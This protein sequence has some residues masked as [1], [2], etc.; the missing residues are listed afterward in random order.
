MIGEVTNMSESN[1]WKTILISHLPQHGFDANEICKLLD[2]ITTAI[3]TSGLNDDQKNECIRSILDVFTAQ[4]INLKKLA[5]YYD[6]KKH[7]FIDDLFHA[8]MFKIALGNKLRYHP[9][10]MPIELVAHI[11]DLLSPKLNDDDTFSL[12]ALLEKSLTPAKEPAPKEASLSPLQLFAVAV[13]LI[14]KDAV[15]DGFTETASALSNLLITIINALKSVKP[16][17]N[18]MHVTCGEYGL[19]DPTGQ[20]TREDIQR[21]LTSAG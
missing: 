12:S 5:T 21:G 13:F 1:D 18:P 11:L 8:D 7:H 19:F 14:I 6:Y 10:S 3:N 9:N 2:S 15:K 16:L 4:N 17:A 20:Q